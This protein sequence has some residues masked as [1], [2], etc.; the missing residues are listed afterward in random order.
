M[1]QPIRW[2]LPASAFVAFDAPL[3]V[4][5]VDGDLDP[6]EI[7]RLGRPAGIEQGFPVTDHAVGGQ[8]REA[9]EPSDD[10][11]GGEPGRHCL[12]G[13]APQRPA[14]RPSGVLGQ[15]GADVLESRDGIRPDQAPPCQQLE[16]QRIARPGGF[17]Q[18]CRPVGAGC[19]VKRAAGNGDRPG[20]KGPDGCGCHADQAQGHGQNRGVAAGAVAGSAASA[21][22]R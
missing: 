20:F 9:L 2:T 12:F 18:G 5:T 17:G 15:E 21:A 10:L 14:V 19:R 16:R 22:A 13:G 6:K 4:A 11:V 3:S 8:G 1:D 7:G